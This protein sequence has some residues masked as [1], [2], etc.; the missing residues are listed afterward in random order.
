[1]LGRP[2]WAWWIT[3]QVTLANWVMWGEGFERCSSTT[4]P[5]VQKLEITIFTLSDQRFGISKGQAQHY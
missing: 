1:M 2:Y 4:T 3:S 5:S